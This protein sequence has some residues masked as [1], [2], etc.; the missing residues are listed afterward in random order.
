MNR[1]AILAALLIAILTAPQALAQTGA[2]AHATLKDRD[3]KVVATANLAQA[4][5]GVSVAI[6]AQGLTPGAHGLHIHAVGLCTAPDFTSAGG[7][8]NPDAKQH[9]LKNPAG[10]HVGDLPNL[11]ADA[12]GKAS[13]TATALRATLASGPTSLFDSDGSAL[14]IHANPDD[15]A[16]DPTGNSG[17]RVAC[18]VVTA[19]SLPS[20]STAA[21]SLGDSALAIAIVVLGAAMLGALAAF[22]RRR[23][24]RGT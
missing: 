2:Q 23:W 18:G 19:G 9:G 15:E 3:G 12:S 24:R 10:A 21:P 14:V 20:T 13:L 8:F 16:T 5:G 17:G 22:G 4:S 7:H 6:A 11:V 1:Y